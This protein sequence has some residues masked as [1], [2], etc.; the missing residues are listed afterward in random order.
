MLPAGS[1]SRVS[2][3]PPA[4]SSR[5]IGSGSAG[6]GRDTPA[7]GV[8][9]V[10][11][12]VAGRGGGAVVPA[13]GRLGTTLTGWVTGPLPPA[14]G[15]M[16]ADAGAVSSAA[17]ALTPATDTVGRGDVWSAGVAAFF[18]GAAFLAAAF[19]GISCVV[20]TESD[21]AAAAF[22]VAVPA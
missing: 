5:S 20:R 10:G 16:S 12:P 9:R 11:A 15:A 21:A 6:C 7:D 22:L 19:F 1:A 14:A 3:A 8:L 2:A 13:G 17:G 18:A 4:T